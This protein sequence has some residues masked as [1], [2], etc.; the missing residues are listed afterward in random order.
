MSDEIEVVQNDEA[1]EW[2]TLDDLTPPDLTVILVINEKRKKLPLKMPSFFRVQEIFAGVPDPMPPFDLKKN[3]AG[4]V[5]KDYQYNDPV[6]INQRMMAVHER[7]I[8]L[9]LDSWR[10]DKL[11]IPG[12]DNAAKIEWL[13]STLT[14]AVMSQLVDVMTKVAG[15]GEAQIEYRA[16][17]FHSNGHRSD[18]GQG[19]V[20]D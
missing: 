10:Q 12:A 17:T 13:K 6:Y 5:V 20:G 18:A 16:E 7:N 8:R 3:D 4:V 19:A 2:A 14:V 1:V 15:K 9:V 11:P